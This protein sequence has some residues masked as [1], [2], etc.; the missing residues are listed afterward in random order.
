MSSDKQV[1]DVEVQ[2][3]DHVAVQ[4]L[5][6][7]EPRRMSNKERLSAYFTIAAAAFGLIRWVPVRAMQF[8]ILTMK[9]F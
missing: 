1:A 2:R 9:H 7:R 4:A 8:Q 6:S 3:D 5:D